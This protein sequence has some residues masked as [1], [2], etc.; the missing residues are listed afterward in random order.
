MLTQPEK[1][2][3]IDLW[4]HPEGL[5]VDIDKK[6]EDRIFDMVR[7]TVKTGPTGKSYRHYQ[8][9]Q[10]GWEFV[11]YLIV[12]LG[13]KASKVSSGIAIEQ[14]QWRAVQTFSLTKDEI[15]CA[16]EKLGEMGRTPISVQKN[17]ADDQIRVVWQDAERAVARIST[18]LMWESRKKE[19]YLK[20]EYGFSDAMVWLW[21]I[22]LEDE[23]V[24]QK[25]RTSHV[26]TEFVLW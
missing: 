22:Y 8:L 12:S 10:K 7:I 15:V 23:N 25:I 9:N 21:S 3:L 26:Q 2:I 1:D 4:Y 18:K 14:R 11:S 6:M 19:D 17:W 13:R 20:K 5:K 16:F 24:R